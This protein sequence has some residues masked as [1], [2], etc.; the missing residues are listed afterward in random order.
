MLFKSTGDAPPPPAPV[1]I[2]RYACNEG[3]TGVSASCSEGSTT[4]FSASCS[5]GEGT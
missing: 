4:A 2:T 5:E 1:T 3:V